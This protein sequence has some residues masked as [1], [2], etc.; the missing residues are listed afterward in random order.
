MATIKKTAGVKSLQ[1]EA[2]TNWNFYYVMKKFIEALV[3][4]ACVK[5]VNSNKCSFLW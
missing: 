4:L 5:K 1:Y 3:G 2:F